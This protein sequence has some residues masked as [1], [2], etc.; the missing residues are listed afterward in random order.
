MLCCVVGVMWLLFNGLCLC[1]WCVLFVLLGV[2]RD[3]RYVFDV[4][5]LFR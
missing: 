2:V 5:L 4:C 1:V 3:L